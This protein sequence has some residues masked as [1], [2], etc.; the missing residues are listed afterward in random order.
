[1]EDFRSDN[2]KRVEERPIKIT[3][4]VTLR[5][6][7]AGTLHL[8]Q[9]LM[10]LGRTDY[11]KQLLDEG[12]VELVQKNL[13]VNSPNYGL[14]LIIQRL[15]S[16]NTYSLNITHGALGTGTATP[17]SSDTQ[18]TT[19]VARVPVTYSADNQ[20]SVAVLQFFFPDATLP[21]DTYTEFGTF[22]DATNTAQ[23]GHM[24]NHALFAT[25]YTK[26][27]GVDITVEVDFTIS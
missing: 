3:G 23:S 7:P 6:Y 26:V 14:D 21:N 4:A 1:M 20:N 9:T 13:I 24:F 27:S 16:T 18:L 11:A 10:E 19:E 22:V 17:A 15:I 8:Y 2:F 12:K 5:S 25:S